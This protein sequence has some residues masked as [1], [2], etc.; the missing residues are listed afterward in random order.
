MRLIIYTVISPLLFFLSCSKLESFET[1]SKE[2]VGRVAVCYWGMVRTLEQC[3]PSH[4]KYVY[5]V[6][7]DNKIE[8]DIFMHTW[9]T[10]GKQW[11]WFWNVDTPNNF[12]ACELLQP[13]H[14]AVEN[15]DEYVASLDYENTKDIYQNFSA[16]DRVWKEPRLVLNLLCALESQRRV[17]D[18]VLQSTEHYDLVIFIRPDVRIVD[19]LP[20]Q[21]MLSLKENDI[22]IPNFAHHRGLN[23]RFA[24]MP[25]TM[26]P[27][28][29][30][31]KDDLPEL[32]QKVD[33]IT[34]ERLLKYI[35]EKYS[36]HI[37]LAEFRFDFVR[38]K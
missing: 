19:P 7:E 33:F 21:E 29:A 12:S 14:L 5:D 37:I 34:S 36:F 1:N 16:A 23:D 9:T 3:Y 17:L 8:Y 26:A 20:I 35:C 4:K 30:Y 25:L 6:L 13:K 2:C 38:P 22:I 10:E 15:Q 24:I 31:R 18:M 11:V 28:Y 32:R 27:H